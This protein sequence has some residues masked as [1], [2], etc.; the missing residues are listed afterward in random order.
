ME[1]LKPILGDALYAQ[2]ADKLKD[3]A[4]VKLAN[5]AGGA[6]VAKEKFLAAATKTA[7]LEKALNEAKAKLAETA[8]AA[9]K[10]AELQAAVQKCIKEKELM[11]KQYELKM[12]AL[13]KAAAIDNALLESKAKNM[14]AVRALVDDSRIVVK[15]GKLTGL[16]E[17]IDAIKNSDPYLF[18]DE[19][20]TGRGSNPPQP[21][22]RA[23]KMNPDRLDDK[24]FYNIKFKK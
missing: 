2:L 3:R 18:D 10:I 23:I 12:F 13:K 14:K 22:D 9:G 1:F 8:D 20:D 16:S 6:Y 11:A 21:A 17:Q 7:A 15:D 24:T 19:R 5:L 4:D